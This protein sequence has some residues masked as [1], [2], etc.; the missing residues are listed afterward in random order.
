MH[1]RRQSSSLAVHCRHVQAGGGSAVTKYRYCLLELNTLCDCVTRGC[2]DD[3]PLTTAAILNG[4]REVLGRLEDGQGD[5][6]PEA[7]VPSPF[8]GQ[9]GRPGHFRA[10][11]PPCVWARTGLGERC[12]TREEEEGREKKEH[13]ERIWRR[14]YSP[15]SSGPVRRVAP[16]PGPLDPI[17]HP[18]V[19][20]NQGLLWE[21]SGL[22]GS[23]QAAK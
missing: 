1:G 4:E 11:D 10:H 5:W 19:G 20:K 9:R 12:R 2:G 16:L 6:W 8:E 23:S 13:L 15:G 17:R 18:V 22:C 3:S 21:F 14:R 7:R